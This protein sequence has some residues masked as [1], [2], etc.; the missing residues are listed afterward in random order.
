MGPLLG[1]EGSGNGFLVRAVPRL[2]R[3]RKGL[4]IQELTTSWRWT[5]GCPLEVRHWLR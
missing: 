2:R 3:W 1:Y 4:Q 5:E